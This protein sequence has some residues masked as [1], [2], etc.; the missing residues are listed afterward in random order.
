VERG[1]VPSGSL[2]LAVR[3]RIAPRPTTAL[4]T[5]HWRER[6]FL[7]TTPWCPEATINEAAAHRPSPHAA[8]RAP[9]RQ[10]KT[11]PR[12]T[13]CTLIGP[14]RR[15]K[16]AQGGGQIKRAR[17]VTALAR[18]SPTRH[19][20]VISPIAHLSDSEAAAKELPHEK[21]SSPQEREPH[22]A[23]RRPHASRPSIATRAASLF[24][25]PP[26]FPPSSLPYYFVSLSYQWP[27]RFARK[28]GKKKIG[29]PRHGGK[30][31]SPTQTR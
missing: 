23:S 4:S 28:E 22:A 10:A 6:L 14:P 18:S 7:S 13:L 8:W 31:I 30:S 5:F 25:P 9:K 15:T 20:S 29:R 21:K 16:R 11:A 12:P 17:L 24:F 27:R 1:P 2:C 26:F 19:L 3:I